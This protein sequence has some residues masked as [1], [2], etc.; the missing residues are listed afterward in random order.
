MR[1]A[2]ATAPANRRKVDGSIDF[3]FAGTRPGLPQ[4][5]GR[6]DHIDVAAKTDTPIVQPVSLTFGERSQGPGRCQVPT[7][8]TRTGKGENQVR[9]TGRIG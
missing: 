8:R 6:P 7:V 9:A 1:E 5:L 2:T 3:P 4:P